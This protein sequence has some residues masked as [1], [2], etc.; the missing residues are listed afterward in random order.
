M[1]TFND[2]K[3]GNYIYELDICSCNVDC[4][5]VSRI[6]TFTPDDRIIILFDNNMSICFHKNESHENLFGVIYFCNKK[7]CLD[8]LSKLAK[9][10]QTILKRAKQSIQKLKEL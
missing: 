10:Y 9:Y 2:L 7:H 4:L 1:K 3:E 8:E 5:K 6:L